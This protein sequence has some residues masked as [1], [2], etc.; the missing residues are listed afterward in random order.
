M[1]A[2]QYSF[3]GSDAAGSALSYLLWE[4]GILGVFLYLVFFYFIYRDARLLTKTNSFVGA[5]ALGWTGIVAIFILTLPF[6]NIF[7]FES[8]CTLFWYLSGYIAAQR[9]RMDKQKPIALEA[10]RNVDITKMSQVISGRNR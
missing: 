8:I 5:L 1:F 6:K 3:I 2:G 10:T 4:I 9:F 7:Y